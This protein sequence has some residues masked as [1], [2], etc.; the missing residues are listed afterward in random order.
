M[1]LFRAEILRLKHKI[2]DTLIV[3]GTRGPTE[4]GHLFNVVNQNCVIRFL[5]GKTGTQV[6]FDGYNSFHLLKTK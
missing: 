6:T 4:A 3:F 5:D 2:P 1:V